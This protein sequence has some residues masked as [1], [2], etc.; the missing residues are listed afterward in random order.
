M[1]DTFV[2]FST[3]LDRSVHGTL[4][5]CLEGYFA[6]TKV[7]TQKKVTY[8]VT[9]VLVGL[10]NIVANYSGLIFLSG[11]EVTETYKQG[12]KRKKDREGG[13]ELIDLWRRVAGC[14]VDRPRLPVAVILS[15]PDVVPIESRKNA[16]KQDKAA[17]S[18]IVLENIYRVR[19]RRVRTTWKLDFLKSFCFRC[20][21]PL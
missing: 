1:A 9:Y 13:N 3:L 17:T 21:S 12:Q 11:K 14:A 18:L 4:L 10:R 7:E 16:R 15:F 2:G 6:R 8:T 19:R 5:R 20:S